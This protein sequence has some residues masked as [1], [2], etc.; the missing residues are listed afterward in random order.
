MLDPQGFVQA[1]FSDGSQLGPVGHGFSADNQQSGKLYYKFQPA[2]GI[3]EIA[4]DTTNPGGLNGGSPDSVQVDWMEQ[5]IQQVSSHYFDA[6]GNLVTTSNPDKLVMLFSHHGIETLDNIGA[7]AVVLPD[8]LHAGLAGRLADGVELEIR[9]LDQAVIGN[10]AYNLVRMA[11]SLAM[12]ARSSSLP[13]VT[14]A[15]MTESLVAGY[16]SAFAG[17][18]PSEDPAGLPEPLKFVVKQAIKRTQKVLM[19]ERVGENQRRFTLGRRFWELSFEEREAV[20]LL[21]R[22]ES[23]QELVRQ[24]EN[25]HDNAEIELVDAAYWV[26]GCSSLGLWQAA[27]LVE[28]REPGKKSRPSLRLLDAN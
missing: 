26:K 6:C 12:S 10:P 4:L 21:T 1:H 22:S 24:I 18:V 11:L 13:G 27:M 28:M 2:P 14:T 5:Q 16:E 9:D 3:L 17:D 8:V 25:R 7:F 23:I 20:E 15:R 19:A